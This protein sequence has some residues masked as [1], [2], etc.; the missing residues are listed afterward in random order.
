MIQLVLGLLFILLAISLMSVDN[1]IKL[2][3][4]NNIT[5]EIED[6]ELTRESL[7]LS[8]GFYAELSKDTY[9]LI[10]SSF[11]RALV[12][13]WHRD[14]IEA[15]N[16]GLVILIETVVEQINVIIIVR[17]QHYAFKFTKS[18]VQTFLNQGESN[19]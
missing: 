12:D 5:H 15:N 2:Q 17:R 7:S 10:I 19:E 14:R 8:N 6:I 9:D 18:D 16:N 11:R 3:Q 4:R 13:D 1:P